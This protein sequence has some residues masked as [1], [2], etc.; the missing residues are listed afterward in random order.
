MDWRGDELLK[1]IREETPDGLFAGAELF[2]ETAASRAPRGATGDLQNSGYVASETKST[3]KSSKKHRKAV[4]PPKGGVV[5]GFAAFYA[6]IVEVGQKPHK[7]GKPG[8]ILRLANGNIVR[9]P[10]DHPGKPARPFIRPTFDELKEQ[11]GN[12][13]VL[14]IRKKIVK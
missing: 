11:I 7:I 5:A 12:T 1:Q 14:K 2:I 8:Q 6:W 3:Y 4:K 10:I 9:G 13:I